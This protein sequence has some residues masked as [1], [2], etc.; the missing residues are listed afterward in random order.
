MISRGR[1]ILFNLYLKEGAS[2][3]VRL[4]KSNKIITSWSCAD[5]KK[6]YTF[7]KRKRKLI[8]Y[9]LKI[10]GCAKCGYNKRSSILEFHHT[11]PK[12]KKYCITEAT[13]ER[14]DLINEVNKCILLCN[15]CHKEIHVKEKGS[16]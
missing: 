2:L 16:D 1:C 3:V 7:Q 14:K 13:I 15:K 6:K 9:K 10:N 5:M 4:Y 11:N 8:M 12:D